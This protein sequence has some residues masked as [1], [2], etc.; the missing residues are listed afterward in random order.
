MHIFDRVPSAYRSALLLLSD[1]R[2]PQ[3]KGTPRA[4]SL[5][6]QL[7]VPL[8][9]FIGE[10]GGLRS[11]KQP[12]IAVRH[13]N[14]QQKARAFVEVTEFKACAAILWRTKKVLVVVV[15]WWGR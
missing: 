1:Q 14:G 10:F 11:T 9:I 15:C 12:V 2:I 7:R 5:D 3:K 8:Q 4:P 13:A 6:G